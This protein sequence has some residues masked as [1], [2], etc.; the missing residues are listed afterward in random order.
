MALTRDEL[1]ARFAELGIA[2]PTK[3]H[4]AIMTV[5]E[6][7]EHWA[8]MPGVH[9][10]NLFLKDAKDKLWLV[11][12]PADLAVDLKTLPDK[13]GSKRLSFGRPELLRE[14]LGVEPGSVTPLAVINDTDRRVTLVLAKSLLDQSPVNVHPLVNTAT[15]ALTPADLLAFVRA[16]GHEP[17]IVALD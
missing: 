14:V 15:T 16:S 17:R 8:D 10:K 5:A 7:L 6:G 4:P 13:I 11:T 12:V 3:D 1:M 9:V 2:A